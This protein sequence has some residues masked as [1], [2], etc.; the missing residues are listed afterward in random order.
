MRQ[1]RR[2][3]TLLFLRIEFLIHFSV[4]YVGGE[5]SV[6]AAADRPHVVGPFFSEAAAGHRERERERERE[7]NLMDGKEEEPKINRCRRPMSGGARDPAAGY[8]LSK[9]NIL[10]VG[11]SYLHPEKIVLKLFVEH[12]I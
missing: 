2:R 6:A 4:L 7:D 11:N 9:V 12:G 8:I 1:G 10:L 3:S 5:L